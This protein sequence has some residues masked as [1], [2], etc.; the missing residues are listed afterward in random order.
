MDGSGGPENTEK[1]RWRARDNHCWIVIA[2]TWSAVIISPSGEL[3]LEK[4]ETECVS[5]QYVHLPQRDNSQGRSRFVARRPDLYGPLVA[6]HEDGHYDGEGK[7]TAAGE[8][9]RQATRRRAVEGVVK[10]DIAD[11]RDRVARHD[12]R[13]D[14][15]PCTYFE[16]FILGNG[17]L[18]AV[19]WFEE[20]RMVLSLDKADVWERRADQSL[21]PGMDYRTALQQVR[22]R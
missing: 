20:D 2:N 3:H 7:L 19:L 11:I 9:R 17:D 15:L 22:D 1:M 16:G 6:G 12:L 13:Y 5:V 18:G 21:E 14:A 8:A 10:D 4:Y